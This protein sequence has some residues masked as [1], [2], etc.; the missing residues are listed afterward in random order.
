[1]TED[2]TM[3][4]TILTILRMAACSAVNRFIYYF[5]RIPLLGKMMPDA[6]Y[7]FGD[8]KVFV[9]V[10]MNVVRALSKVFYKAL[11]VFVCAFVPVMFIADGLPEGLRP[12]CFAVILAF[13]S[14]LGGI[15][16]P[17]ALVDNTPER[18]HCVKL[19][20][21][22]AGQYAL[23][24]FALKQVGDFL[25]FLPGVLIFGALAGLPLGYGFL[26]TVLI[27]CAHIIGEALFVLWVD[28]A[29]A[30]YGAKAWFL[31]AYVP[32]IAGAYVPYVLA[33][34]DIQTAFME[35]CYRGLFSIPFIL[36]V[37]LL[38]VISLAFIWR[39]PRYAR[40]NFLTTDAETLRKTQNMAELKAQSRFQDVNLQEKKDFRS[41]VGNAKL[42]RKQGYEYLNAL[43]FER[44][45]RMLVRPVWVTAAGIA[46]V[47]VAYVVLWWIYPAGATDLAEYIPNMLP[48][49]VFLMYMLTLY[50]GE[51][52]CRAMFHN[53]DL[54]LLR[55]A[56]YREPR[57]I[58]QNFRIRLRIIAKMNLCI[59]AVI[60]TAIWM[61]AQLS[62]ISWA[63][64]EQV[65]VYLCILC[66]GF[67]FSIHHLFL[68]YVFQPYTV[69]E[70][71]KNPL[72][73]II[74]GVVYLACFACLQLDST[75]K[76]FTPFV[77]VITVVYMAVALVCINKFAP[78]NFRV[79]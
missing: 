79:K 4:T 27:V 23:A 71:T 5:K 1:M 25:A 13:M 64:T 21:M 74:N 19:M 78:K 36:A 54:A 55:Y 16:R 62:G 14:M 73:N 50:T 15:V 67:F 52:A 41:S 6:A 47:A 7:G 61:A 44:H 32:G 60:C 3:L 35:Q 57:V 59:T 56:Y 17:G 34:M 30:Y 20:R 75:P 42:S 11:Y 69:D 63:W 18:Y 31:L 72:F 22:P 12:V 49:C 51:R 70:N 58:L 40:I 43:F 66:L 76:Y 48:M 38:A 46:L 26:L 28:K 53:C 33:V 65:L 37:I 77:L 8:I 68:Y 29:G 39:Y 2:R 10:V 9:T 45:R 24:V